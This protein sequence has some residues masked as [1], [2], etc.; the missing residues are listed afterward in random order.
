MLRLSEAG[1]LSAQ[2][3][4]HA[5]D[6]DEDDGMCLIKADNP[7][8]K[9][10][11]LQLDAQAGR[12]IDTDSANAVGDSGRRD[13][14]RYTTV[15]DTR[16]GAWAAPGENALVKRYAQRAASLSFF[17]ARIFSFTVA[18]LAANHC[19]SLVKGL[20]PLRLGLAGTLTAVIFSRPGMV[21]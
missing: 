5:H 6:V 9:G 10:V 2:R 1:A 20:M 15:E 3:H 19:S 16:C 18:G 14:R 11:D 21:K 7:A 13:A 8:D 12:G 4:T 17:S